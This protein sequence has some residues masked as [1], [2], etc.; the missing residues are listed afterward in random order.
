MIKKIAFLVFILI[1]ALDLIGLIFK[2]E[3]L[4]YLFKPFIL[5]SL[6]F[7]YSKSVFEI[8]KWYATALIFSFFGDVFLIYP[9]N[10]PFKIG[11]V[12]FLIA[13]LLFI[14]IV[15]HRIKKVSFS[16]ILTALILFGLFLYLLIFAL[17]DS[18]G[19][20]FV[21]V[22]IYGI[23]ISAF[24]VVSL[25]DFLN[26]KSKKSLL[27]LFGAIVFMISDSLLAINKFYAST[28]LFEVLIMITYVLAQY[29]IF[30]SIILDTEKSS[31]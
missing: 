24:G 20:L 6:L 3:S 8:N 17:K 29:L 11:L 25:L 7:L 31:N 4:L 10:F 26:T 30:R 28:H 1:S 12:S 23:T 27:M 9:G 14:K 16:K 2:I 5:L 22:I 21:P 13:H 19:E 18:L 15:I